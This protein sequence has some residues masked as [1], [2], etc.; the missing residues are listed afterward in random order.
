MFTPDPPTMY[1]DGFCTS[2][3]VD[4]LSSNLE[5]AI[6]PTHFRG[7]TTVVLKLL[8]QVQPD[9]AIF[10]AKDYQ[11]QAIIRRMVMDLD[12]PVE[13]LTAPTM[14]E[15]DGLAMS[16]RNAYLSPEQRAS[17]IALFESLIL[18]EDLLHGGERNVS[19]VA[20]AMWAHMQSKPPVTPDYAVI[21]DPVTLKELT[22]PQPKM[23]A[24]VAARLGTTRL[25]DNREI[26][27]SA[28]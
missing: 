18:A 10:G 14:R 23:V 7:V 3:A 6:R 26:N 22:E 27:L 24:L 28:G 12:V 17:A 8:N 20:E 2:V 4:G 5:G 25:I 15:A 1:P 21:A 16:S 11:Q 13:I 9:V 19:K